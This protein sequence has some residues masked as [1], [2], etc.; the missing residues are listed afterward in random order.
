VCRD[1]FPISE[2][3]LDL[4]IKSGHR[5][6]AKKEQTNKVIDLQGLFNDYWT[7]KAHQL[8]G[9]GSVVN[10]NRSNHI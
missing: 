9:A 6:W 10:S 7:S 1:V 4:H 2:M 5:L 3:R 8:H